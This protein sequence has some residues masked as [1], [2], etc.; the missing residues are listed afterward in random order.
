MLVAVTARVNLG[1][2]VAG[3]AGSSPARGII[4]VFV[5]LSVMSSSVGGGLCDELI[6]RPRV[7]Q[8]F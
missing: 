5:F 1:R 3:I 6:T 8:H 2:F 4:F 7:P